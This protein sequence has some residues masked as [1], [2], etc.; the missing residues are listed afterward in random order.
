M[1]H[2]RTQRVSP[3]HV[4]WAYPK[5][6]KGDI[7]LVCNISLKPIFHQNAKSF[8]LGTFASPNAKDSSFALPKARNI[9]M[10]VPFALDDSNSSRFTRRVLPRI[11]SDAFYPTPVSGIKVALGLLALGLAL[12]MYISYFLC[13]FHLRLVVNAKP[14]FSGIWA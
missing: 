13:R 9:N 11:L 2:A 6:R 14:V 8:T 7:H 4:V 10:L 12:G 5:T 1:V 3:L